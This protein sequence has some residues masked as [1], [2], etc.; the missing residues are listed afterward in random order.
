MLD[1]I[2]KLSDQLIEDT[3]TNR[4]KPYLSREFRVTRPVEC[5][6]ILLAYVYDV[7]WI[8]LP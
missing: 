1:Y 7:T 4:F 2:E 5:A 3:K 6:Q 8:L